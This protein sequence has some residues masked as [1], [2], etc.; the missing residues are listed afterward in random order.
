M[1]TRNARATS[2]ITAKRAA[3]PRRWASYHRRLLKVRDQ[4]RS[5]RDE[6]ERA[7]REPVELGGEDLADFASARTERTKLI[8]AIAGEEAEL[9]EIEAALERIRCGT[10]GVCEAT[11][12][13][14]DAARLRA[15]PWTRLSAAAAK[16]LKP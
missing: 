7:V 16:R 11:R 5:E 14:I 9:A 6:Q 8:A 13:P 12:R 10:Y 1:K 15:I 2:K 4:L 3:V